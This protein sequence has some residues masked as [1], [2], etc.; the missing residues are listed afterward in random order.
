MALSDEIL[1]KL[2]DIARR[3]RIDVLRMLTQAGSGHTGGSLSAVD[4]ITVLYFH[5]MRHRPDDPAWPGRDRFVLSKGHAA[6]A[7]YAALAQAGYFPK[8]ELWRLRRAEGILQGHPYSLSTPGVEVST[9][10]L[11]Q[12]L[13]VA[14]GLAL[15]A[16]LDGQSHRIYVLLG[17]GEV[18]EGQ[19]WE[20]AMSAA[21]YRLDNVCALMDCN[22]LQ[23][24]GAV[25]E[26]MG[27]EPLVEKWRAFGW[28]V[29]EIDGH[30][31]AAIAEALDRADT[32]KGRPCMI[33]ARTVKGKGV[34]F[35]EGQVKYHGI[36]PTPEELERALAEL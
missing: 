35:M 36:A 23:I 3:L 32:V 19:V 20:A 26:I 28:E 11:G 8:E 33:L 30:N 13:S 15:A 16:K 10:S 34:S 29:Q 31:L 22:G 1:R 5:K 12:G 18:Q 9:G 17:D 7:L 6:P 27:I 14:N 25:E 4:I 21:H 24:D 2:E